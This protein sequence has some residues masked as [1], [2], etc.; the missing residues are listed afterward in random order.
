MT[1][2][3]RTSARILNGNALAA[4]IR[5]GLAEEAR[6]LTARGAQ[7]GLAV[8]L[9]G[10][11]PASHI[12]VRKK[13]EACA[14]AGFRTFDHRLP[15]TTSEDELLG[16]V[17][18]LNADRRVDGI[19]VQV[20]LPKGIDARRVL[21]AVDPTKD[22]DGFHPDNLGR[23]LMGEPRFIAC[24]PFGIM[25]LIEEAGLPLAGT[26]A[27][28]VGR[29]NTVGKPIAAL[30]I[31]ADATVTVCHSRTRDLAAV[32]GRADV[33]VAAAGRAEM[34]R[35]AW[36]KPGAVVID[37]GINRLPTGKLVGD[38]EFAA[39]AER[40]SAIT[41]V[42]GGVGPMTV[43]MLLSNTLLAARNRAR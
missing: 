30:L 39:A 14:E 43:A 28:V 21:L 23:L 18:T 33:L 2:T 26:D 3:A 11:D 25:K 4:R 5:A 13:T 40:A 10:D 34:I 15:A 12:Y 8:V 17:A 7:P 32:V 20:P 35:G 36:I 6:A 38:V 24:T 27:V 41:P 16:L 29:S 9:V 37:V 1:A 31:A 42:P 22:V 19:L